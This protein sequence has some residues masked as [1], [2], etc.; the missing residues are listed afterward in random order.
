MEENLTTFI[1]PSIRRDTL[2]RALKSVENWPHLVGFDDK[3]EG[4]G[5]IRNRLIEQ[6]TTPWVSFLDD[7]DSVTADYVERLKEEIQ[8]NPDAEI[9][10]FRQYFLRGLLLPG[11][12]KVEWGNIGIAYSMK[13]ELA[14]K[15]PFRS[16]RHEDYEHVKRL[17]EN[18]KKVVFSPYITYRVRH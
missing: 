14:L 11:W 6:A 13:R 8:K 18:G 17:F 12:P 10:H 9:I 5:V 16:E 7:D 3:H 1:I 4:E 2:D 15:Y